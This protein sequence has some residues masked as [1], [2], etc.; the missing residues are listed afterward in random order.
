[1]II[2]LSG[3]AQSGKDTVAEHLISN[4]GYRRVAF[5]DPIRMALYKLNPVVPVGEFSSTHLAQAVDGL[6]WEETKRL[7][8]ETRRLLQVLG[9]E[10]G[11]EMFGPDFW[12]N[13]AMNSF[14]KFDKVVL[15]DVRYPNEYKAIKD[16]DGIVIR[17]TKPGTTAINA[18]ESE[19]ALDNHGFNGTI[20]N[21][22]SKEDLYEKIDNL[23][24]EYLS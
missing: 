13:Q 4:F 11:R 19:T 14:G 18:H 2:G 17:I 7:S 16:R 3:Y 21:D 5:A 8:P 23:I 20:V 12:V 9:T 24:K 1:M 22:G 10:V 6:G 15:T